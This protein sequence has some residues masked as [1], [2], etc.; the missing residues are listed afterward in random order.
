M[1]S[2]DGAQVKSE[3][4]SR[5]ITTDSC[6]SLSADWKC[7]RAS[8]QRTGGLISPVARVRIYLPPFL[9]PKMQPNV[10]LIS[11]AAGHLGYLDK[12]TLQPPHSGVFAEPILPLW[13]L[14]SVKESAYFSSC[15]MA[16]ICSTLSWCAAR[17]LSK[18]SCFRSNARTSVS[19]AVS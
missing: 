17:S 2:S 10:V 11:G 9:S 18:A 3:S 12:H 8:G 6:S 19:V 7:Q 16:A 4:G 15:A 5:R 1:S 13:V 14:I